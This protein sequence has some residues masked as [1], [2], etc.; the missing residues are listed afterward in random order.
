MSGRARTES[1]GLRG[2]ST[3]RTQTWPQR[4]PLP[5]PTVPR[6]AAGPGRQPS[7]ASSGR[8][9]APA[10]RP[11][12]PAPGCIMGNVVRPHGRLRLHGVVLAARLGQSL[13][14]GLTRVGDCLPWCRLLQPPGQAQAPLPSSKPRLDR[15]LRVF[16]PSAAGAN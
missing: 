12:R 11:G 5:S 15:R 7:P 3:L 4:G 1:A 6:P 14:R 2:H 13:G 8:G 16:G 10:A 9:P